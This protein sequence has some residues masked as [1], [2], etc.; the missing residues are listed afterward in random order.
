MSKICASL[1]ALIIAV[2]LAFGASAA[3]DPTRAQGYLD[4][5]RKSLEDRK[6]VV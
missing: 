3:G 6:S 4:D 2:T 1:T 5:A